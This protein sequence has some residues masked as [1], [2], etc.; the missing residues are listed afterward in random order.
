MNADKL[1]KWYVAHTKPR[2]ESLA[3]ECLEHADLK[4]YLPLVFNRLYAGRSL[5][6]I[7]RPMFPHY[8]FVQCPPDPKHWHTICTTRG[9]QRILGGNQ[10]ISVPDEAIEA[11]KHFETECTYRALGHRKRAIINWPFG[12]GDTVRITKGPFSQFYAELTTAVDH[13]GRVKALVGLFKRTSV[14]E[15]SAE[16]LEEVNK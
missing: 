9:I 7:E 12:I 6:T 4:A 1:P 2:H 8:L 10:P 16:D 15:L 5:R 13:R 3:K 14:A 11:V